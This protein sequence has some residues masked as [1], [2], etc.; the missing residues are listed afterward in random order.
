[1]SGGPEGAAHGRRVAVFGLDSFA[2][3]NRAQ[4]AGMNARGYAFDVFTNDTMG[5]S[6]AHLPAGNSLVRLRPG[7]A[8]RT[9]QLASYLAAHRAELNHVEVYPGGRYAGIYAAL[10]RAY[11]VP[12][13]T[14]ERGD[15][16]YRDR[17]GTTTWRSMQ[18]CYRLSSVVWYRELYQE[19]LLRE[20]GVRRLFFLANAVPVADDAP[21]LPSG[22]TVDF[23]WANRLIS[24]RKA[25]WVADLLAEPRFAGTRSVMLGF[26][27]AADAATRAQQAYV[28]ERRTPNLEVGPFSDPGA[29]FRS[30]RFFLLP[31][32]IVFCNHALLE[33]MAH[34]VVPL[35]SDVEGA[36]L[37]VDHGVD[38]LVFPHS[39]EGLGAAMEAAL[40]L[41]PGEVAR[42]SRAAV[43]K[44]R[45]R[46]SA[47]RWC[48]TL[49]DEYRRLGERVG[50][51]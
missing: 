16:L 36:R 43:E 9:A 38:G 26:L 1:V 13:M 24:E 48:D 3:K 23:A 12:L 51:G 8:G 41:G 30:A 10:A 5:D 11:G 44:V 45:T 21:P 22:R 39:P 29:L 46:F 6:A 34:G 35:V 7:I 47:E 32:D 27:D 20:M 42:M 31:S 37:I 17:Y 2:R 18:L 25:T 28:R 40:A 14:V 33:A 19:R 49:A 15:L 50:G 4:V